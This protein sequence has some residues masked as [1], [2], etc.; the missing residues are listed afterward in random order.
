MN[1]WLIAFGEIEGLRWVLDQGQMA[2][3]EGLAGRAAKMQVGDG[4]V[5]YVTRGAFHNP[6]RDQSQLAGIATVTSPVRRL[7][8]PVSIG[9]REFAVVCRLDVKVSLSERDGVPFAPLIRRMRFIRRKDAWGQYLR[10][11]LIALPREDFDVLS[12]A[13]YGGV[14]S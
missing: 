13:I 12:K 8:K 4:L 6:S 3:S 14:R 10:A 9:G 7:P 5:L 11:G 1:G 2:F